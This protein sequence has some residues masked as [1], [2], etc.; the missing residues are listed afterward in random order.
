M[1]ACG[2]QQVCWACTGR[3][4]STCRARTATRVR[5]WGGRG[6]IGV[7]VVP[8]RLHVHR[9]PSHHTST[10][11]LVCCV[12]VTATSRPCHLPAESP[13]FIFI[14]MG[15]I[16]DS[17]GQVVTVCFSSSHTSNSLEGAKVHFKKHKNSCFSSQDHRHEIL[18]SIKLQQLLDP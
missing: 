17:D 14:H 7:E 15:P 11:D 10:P 5:G 13:G 9:R 12:A 16:A 3:V 1:G 2:Q 8:L 18:L 6:R 4:P